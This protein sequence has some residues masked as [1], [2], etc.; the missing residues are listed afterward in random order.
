MPCT[1]PDGTAEIPAHIASERRHVRKISALRIFYHGSI[2]ERKSGKTRKCFIFLNN[3]QKYENIMAKMF[4][5]R[6]VKAY[7]QKVS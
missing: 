7:R 5:I 3:K 2:L 6:K 1:V 4:K